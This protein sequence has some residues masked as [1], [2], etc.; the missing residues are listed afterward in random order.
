M[1]RKV[2][3]AACALVA[4]AGAATAQIKPAA[5]SAEVY[6]VLT[7]TVP[8]GNMEKF[9]HVV[10]GLVAASKQEPGTLEYEYAA[11]ADN[12]TVEIVERYIDSDAVVHHVVDNFGARFSK[13]FLALVKPT[14]FVVFGTPNAKAKEVLAAFNPVY[15]T[16]FDGFTR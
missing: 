5:A 16:P 15:L 8:P 4:M 10:A 2:L 14:R 11:S 13:D 3:L 12:G 1:M 9:K 6:W 7:V